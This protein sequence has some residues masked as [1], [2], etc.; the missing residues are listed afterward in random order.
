[1]VELRCSY[2]PDSR[3]GAGAGK[4]KVGATIHWVSAVDALPAEASL[5]RGRARRLSQ[6]TSTHIPCIRYAAASSSAQ[7]PPIPTARRCSSSAKA[8]SATTMI[9]APNGWS[10]IERPRCAREP[11]KG[12]DSAPRPSQGH[13][14][15]IEIVFDLAVVSYPAI[16]ERFFQV[17]DPSTYEQQGS[18]FGPSFYSAIFYTGR[19]A[20]RD[21]TH[22]DWVYD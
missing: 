11:G 21:G 18:N 3:G 13:A 16:L 9:P 22:D 1:M 15:A 20:E 12:A 4:R 19:T 5:Q 14:E 6:P 17:H 10:S 8:I 2:D 7:P